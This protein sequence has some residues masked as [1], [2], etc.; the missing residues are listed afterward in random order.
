MTKPKNRVSVY[1]ARADAMIRKVAGSFCPGQKWHMDC[2][3]FTDNIDADG[4][5][6][7]C[8]KDH[9]GYEAQE[10]SASHKLL[11]RLDKFEK[12]SRKKKMVVK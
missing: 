3:E 10:P 8:W 7:K 2:S 9:L 11:S 4:K 5:C 6:I 12:K 1:K